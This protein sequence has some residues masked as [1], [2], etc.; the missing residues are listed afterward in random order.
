MKKFTVTID[1]CQIPVYF[2]DLTNCMQMRFV[3]DG[4]NG[5]EDG[6]D[7]IAGFWLTGTGIY[8]SSLDRMVL[9]Y[10]TYKRI[11]PDKIYIFDE[12]P[13][14]LEDR[15]RVSIDEASAFSWD[16]NIETV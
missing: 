6:I 5:F 14:L 10:L 13:F 1:G 12:E 2:D 8:G 11:Y 9:H 4:R 16:I 3:K 15:P 7:F